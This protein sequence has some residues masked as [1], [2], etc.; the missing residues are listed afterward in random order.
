MSDEAVH[1]SG[2]VHLRAATVGDTDFLAWGLNEAAGGLFVTMLGKRAPTILGSVVSQPA[3]EYSFEH[4]VVAMKAGSPVGFCQGMPYG[5]PSGTDALMRVAGIRSIRAGAVA[6]LGRPVF[7]ALER[8]SPGEW[9]LQAMAVQSRA[10]GSGVGQLLFADAFR[11]AAV[12]GCR[13]LTLDVD[14]A[15]TRARALY[16]R[17]GLQVVYS[18]GKAVLLDGAQIHRMSAPVPEG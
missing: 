7:S 4:A 3:H 9:Y 15:N 18:S 11:R 17:L 5:T 14:A 10:R 16:E 12:A 13:T 6:L 2:D 1:P 8:H